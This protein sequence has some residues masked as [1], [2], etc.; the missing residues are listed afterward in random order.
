MTN[1]SLITGDRIAFAPAAE[2][3]AFTDK[4][5]RKHFLY[6]LKYSPYYQNILQKNQVNPN[7]IL[8][9]DDLPRLPFTCK[10][11]LEMYGK[12]FVCISPDD[13]SDICQTSGTTGKAV[14][15]QQSQADIYRLGY[16]EEMSFRAAGITSEDRLLVACALGRCFMAGLAYFEGARRLGATTIRTGSGNAAFL[17]EQ[18][19]LHKP[20][21][22][23][24]VPSV[25][26]NTATELEQLSIQAT[27]IGVRTIV[28]IGEPI[29]NP[30]LSPSA[31]GQRLAKTWGAQV[32]GTYASTE[33][34]TAFTECCPGDGGGHVQAELM[35]VE[36]VDNAGNSVAA[37][38]P[39]EVVGTPL[40]VTGM[41]LLRFKTG[42]IAALYEEPCSCGRNTARLGPIL[43]RKQQMLKIQGTTV[44]P[45]AIFTVLETFPNVQDYY[46]EVN[47]DYNLSESVRLI[48]ATDSPDDDFI[49]KLSK[50]L[51]A[52][53]R[54]SLCIELRSPQKVQEKTKGS[55]Q[56][57]T[58]R[59][60]DYRNKES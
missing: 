43:G 29:R 33:L 9:V 16:N 32:L 19:T 52:K 26:L 6:C 39:G 41:P 49:K 44:Y 60:F 38:I 36:I 30:D 34:A 3:K 59:F 40:Q 56:R 45:Q 27:A 17:A 42:D 53:L 2:I 28:G 57:K 46:L 50:Q 8:G 11:D 18:I 22:I 24:G 21:V 7:L 13:F 58:V 47:N 37:G 55:G 14:T 23:V 5:L 31:L 15:L 12:D 1:S 20:T 54:I 4:L 51:Q 35:A 25:L 48:V 10:K